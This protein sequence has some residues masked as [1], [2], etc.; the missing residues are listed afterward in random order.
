MWTGPIQSGEGALEE[1]ENFLERLA[2]ALGQNR[3]TC[4]SPEK[5]ATAVRVGSIWEMVGSNFWIH[6][7]I[8]EC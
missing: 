5:E 7:S 1:G 4:S 8:G 2:L 6:T 3:G